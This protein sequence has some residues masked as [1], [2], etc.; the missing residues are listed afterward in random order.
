MATFF[1]P[2][3]LT[4]ELTEVLKRR[5]K[6]YQEEETI[7]LPKTVQDIYDLVAKNTEVKT[8]ESHE[9]FYFDLKSALNFYYDGL[10]PR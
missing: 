7:Q 5:N 4:P 9:D 2:V 10:G 8:Y 6:K 1:E 3:E